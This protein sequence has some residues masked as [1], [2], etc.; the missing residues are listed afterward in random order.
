MTRKDFE[1]IAEVIAA[2]VADVDAGSYGSY[3]RL[4]RQA[5][6]VATTHT[7]AV[8]LRTTNPNFNATRFVEAALGPP[9]KGVSSLPTK[10]ADVESPT[11]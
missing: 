1:L 3:T 2:R 6:L 4:A 5:E 10:L 11:S 7:L 8:A 9:P